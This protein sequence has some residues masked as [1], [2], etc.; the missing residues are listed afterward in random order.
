[1]TSL[2]ATLHASKELTQ[3]LWTSFASLLRSHVAMHSIARSDNSLRIVSSSDSSVELLGLNGK[4]ILLARAGQALQGVETGASHQNVT[5]MG[6][7][8]WHWPFITLQS[9]YMQ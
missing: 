6:L 1:M 3:E 2:V 8:E 9:F 5:I 7:W 4:L